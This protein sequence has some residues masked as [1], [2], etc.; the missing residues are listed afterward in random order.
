[1]AYEIS[2]CVICLHETTTSK[3]PSPPPPPH[4]HKNPENP[5]VFFSPVQPCLSSISALLRRQKPLMIQDS[6]WRDK[7]LIFC[8]MIDISRFFLLFLWCLSRQANARNSG[9]TLWLMQQS[10]G[11]CLSACQPPGWKKH[12]QPLSQSLLTQPMVWD[13]CQ[14]KRG[15]HALAECP[16]LTH[17][18]LLSSILMSRLHWQGLGIPATHVC[19]SSRRDECAR[20]RGCK[21]PTFSRLRIFSC[22]SATWSSNSTYLFKM[23]ADELIKTVG[24]KWR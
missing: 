8:A 15:R 11:M 10:G 21:S 17:P 16:T 5:V 24:G 23:S 2:K 13:E 3:T 7:K 4:S 18:T 1:M 14:W 22:S 19:A 9:L 12:N 6:R 20:K